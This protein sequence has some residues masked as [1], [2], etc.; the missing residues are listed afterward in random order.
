MFSYANRAQSITTIW[1]ESYSLCKQSFLQVLPWAFVL[2]VI[3]LLISLGQMT[4]S[5]LT[6]EG[7]PEKLSMRHLSVW[8]LFGIILNML[9]SA[10]IYSAILYRINKIAL[11]NDVG[12]AAAFN[13][14]RGK[15]LTVVLAMFIDLALVLSGLVALILPGIFLSVALFFYMPLILFNDNTAWES[16][17]NSIKLV[18]GDWW[19]TFLVIT[20]P[21]IILVL[22]SVFLGE[23]LGEDNFLVDVIVDLVIMPF[24]I[25]FFNALILVQFNDLKLRKAQGVKQIIRP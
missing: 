14:A 15:F 12:M 19:R 25:P 24:F 16:I 23:I 10:F 6:T 17:K 21:L 2:S 1:S 20:F 8:T 7:T 3:A 11:Q 18:W 13:V 22:V 4:G 9:V 5:D